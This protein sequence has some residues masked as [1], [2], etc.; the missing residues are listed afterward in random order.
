MHIG[1]LTPEYVMSGHI[2]GGLA[3]YIKKTSHGL[4]SRGHQ[5]TVIVLSERNATWNDGPVHICEVNKIE[6]PRWMKGKQYHP[7]INQILCSHLIK[8]AVWKYH[9]AT[10]FDIFQASSYLTPGFA[11]RNNGRVPLICRVSS[12]TPLCRAAQGMAHK[13]GDYLNEW[14]ELH[15]IIDADAAFAPSYFIAKALVHLENYPV[16]VIR[17]PLTSFDEVWDPV[18]FQNTL[19]D[20]QYILYYGT[21]NRIKGVDLLAEVLPQILEQYKDLFVVMIGRD[22]SKLHG[23]SYFDYI[24]SKCGGVENKLHYHSALTKSQLYPIISNAIGVVLPSRIDNYPNVCLEAL[25]LLVPVVGTYDSSLEEM[26]MDGETGFL[27]ENSN[28]KSIYEAILRL[29]NQ[30]SSER[31]KMRANIQRYIEGIKAEDRVGQ[32]IAFY[33]E[34]IKNYKNKKQRSC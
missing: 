28:P 25:S 3:N 5:V 17:T 33:E 26:I 4:A 16:R 10:P 22:N 8:R 21:F 32:L 15:Q 18:Y 7:F 31:E 14:L 12:Y 11:L 20:K 24:R 6:I 1:F 30:K 9:Q 34:V 23:L 29:L 19:A 27:A 2:D 13:F